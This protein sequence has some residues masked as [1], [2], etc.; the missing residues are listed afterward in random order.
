MILTFVWNCLMYVQF[1][2]PWRIDFNVGLLARWGSD[3]LDCGIL[4]V[5]LA[6]RDNHQAQVQFVLEH[7]LPVIL[8]V[9]ALHRLPFP[10]NS[11]DMAHCSRCLIPWIDFVY[12]L[13]IHRILRPG[14]FWVFSGP[15]INYERRWHGWDTTVE[16]QRSNYE[17]LQDL[18]TSLCFELYNKK[19]DIAVWQKSPDSVCYINQTRDTYPPKC[20]DSLEADPTCGSALTFKNDN[21]S[22]IDYPVCIMIVVSSYAPNTLPVIYDRGLI[23]TFHDWCEAFST[24][25]RTYDLLHLAGLFTAESHRCLDWIFVLTDAWIGYSREDCSRCCL[26]LLG[27]I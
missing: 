2:F 24:Y 20:D 16:E 15:P 22:L 10:S 4:T 14:G 12:L 21:T 5:S 17:K 9:L 3:L 18:L 1:V 23:G 11:F 7:D 19:G 8:G 6:P 27:P 25:P 26:S 13:E